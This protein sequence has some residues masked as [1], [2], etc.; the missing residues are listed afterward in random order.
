MVELQTDSQN[1][2]QGIYTRVTKVIK[3]RK[4]SVN[5]SVRDVKPLSKYHIFALNKRNSQ[6]QTPS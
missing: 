3:C 6:R 2:M 4:R 5:N 1:A